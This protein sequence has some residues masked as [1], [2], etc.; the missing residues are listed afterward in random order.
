MAQNKGDEGSAKARATEAG[1]SALNLTLAKVKLGAAVEMATTSE[2]GVGAVA[3]AY[4]AISAAGN[5]V[6]GTVQAIG[7][8]TGQTKI[9]ETAAE[10]VATATSAL[11]MG[12]LIA[13]GGNLEKASTAAA[14]EGI[15]TSSPK[16]LATGGT[17]ARAAKAIDLMQNIHQVEQ[18]IKSWF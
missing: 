14:I 13:T 7:A 6:A 16:D 5:F 18:K 11:G 12:T 10:V 1:E 2:T 8:A 3:T 9:T 17:V 15:V 4:T